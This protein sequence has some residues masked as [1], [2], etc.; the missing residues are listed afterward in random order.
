MYRKYILLVI[1]IVKKM[2]E[3]FM[4]KIDTDNKK[5]DI[6]ILRNNP[7]QRSDDSTITEFSIQNFK[8]RIF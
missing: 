4:K 6:L 1:L 7:I 2:L 5:K 8:S 3:R